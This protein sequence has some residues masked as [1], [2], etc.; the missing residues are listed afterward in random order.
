[1]SI[2]GPSGPEPPPSLASA[3]GGRPL[4]EAGR[5]KSSGSPRG[6][7]APWLW[8]SASGSFNCC[9]FDFRSQQWDAVPFC[10]PRARSVAHVDGREGRYTKRAW[11]GGELPQARTPSTPRAEPSPLPQGLRV[12]QDL[13]LSRVSVT[14]SN[15]E[16]AS[17]FSRPGVLGSPCAHS[18]P[19]NPTN[20][21][22]SLQRS[23]SL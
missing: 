11:S 2:T 3:L 5:A 14:A 15:P 22:F 12:A 20:P 17:L 21:V 8:G 10:S 1:M 19:H 23:H 6:W 4:K 13:H 7:G 16:V 18:L 9:S